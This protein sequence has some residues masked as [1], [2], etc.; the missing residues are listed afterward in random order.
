M[1]WFLNR[2]RRNRASLCLLASGV[3]S[4]QETAEIERHLATCPGCRKFYAEIKMTTLPFATWEKRFEHIEPRLAVQMRWTN[5]IKSADRRNS[6]ALFSPR[7][8]LLECWRQLIWPSRRIWSGLAAVWLLILIANLDF[9]ASTPRMMAT[10]SPR[11]AD[12]IMAF[13]EQQQVMAELTDHADVKAIEPPTQFVP[14]P[15]SEWHSRLF[16]I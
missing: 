5:E 14:R 7:A 11:S 13:R 4:E 10:T 3:L 1:K 8:V 9:H 6:I 2:C 12:F 16:T 15:R